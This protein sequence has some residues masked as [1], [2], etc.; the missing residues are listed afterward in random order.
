MFQFSDRQHE[1]VSLARTVGR[2]LVD[3]L[4]E[5]FGVTP[6]TIRRDLGELCER[7][8]LMRT[9][10]GAVVSSSVENL[11]YEARRFIAATSKRAIGVAAAALIPNNS[12]LFINIGTTTEEVAVALSGHEVSRDSQFFRGTCG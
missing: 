11:S 1:I 7:N 4:A 6:Q 12:S 8:I 9:H 2:V 3:E 5:K 10:G